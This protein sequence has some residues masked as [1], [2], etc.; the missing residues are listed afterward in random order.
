M[1]LSESTSDSSGN[2][3]KVSN[4]NKIFSSRTIRMA[5]FSLQKASEL[6]LSNVKDLYTIMEWNVANNIHFFRISSNIF[7]FID[8]PELGYRINSLSDAPEIIRTLQM[9]GDIARSNKIRLTCHP[10]PYTCIAS[11]RQNVIDKSLMSIECHAE[12][13]NIL[14]TPDFA[15]NIHVGGNYYDYYEQTAIS[16]SNSFRK[17]SQYAQS[18]L[19][20]ENDDRGSLWSVQKLYD[21]IYKE[22]G[23]PIVMDMH[24]WKF[25]HDLPNMED[26]AQ[27]ALSTWGNRF[28]KMHYSESRPKAKPQAHSDYIQDKIPVLSSNIDYD[29]M[30]ETKQKDKA[31]LQYRKG[32][33]V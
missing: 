18:I 4:K 15:I 9:I 14:N 28:P 27:L 2:L 21:Y 10:G 6:A 17:L 24:H 32:Q 20:V 1:N 16:F 25:N 7:P 33:T 23:I 31:L 8:H 12:L 29:I 22:T 5:N 26:S 11:P 30:L 3:V 19:T 13:A